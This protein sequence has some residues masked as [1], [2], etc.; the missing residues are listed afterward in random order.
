MNRWYRVLVASMALAAVLC[1]AAAA[2]A[3]TRMVRVGNQLLSNEI[4]IRA[5]QEWWPR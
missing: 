2:Y 4:L 3:C 1:T 5:I